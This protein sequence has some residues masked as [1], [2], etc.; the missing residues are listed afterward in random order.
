MCPGPEDGRRGGA[1]RP[2]VTGNP[3]EQIQQDLTDIGYSLG[4][5][6]GDYGEKTH[7]AVMM[8]QEHFLVRGGAVN[9]DGRVDYNTAT[10]IQSALE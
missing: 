9:P 10:L 2:A 3:V 5:P 7:F 4:T 8:F 6:D 1:N